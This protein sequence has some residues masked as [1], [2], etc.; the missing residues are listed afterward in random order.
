MTRDMTPE[1]YRRQSNEKFDRKL[2]HRNQYIDDLR[3]A[4][5][6]AGERGNCTLAQRAAYEQLID[7]WLRP[8]NKE[9]FYFPTTAVPL[10]IQLLAAQF[11]I[12]TPNRMSATE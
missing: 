10:V 7:N 1:D 4:V 3:A 11:G 5:R 9:H 6:D 8:P 12:I 2:A